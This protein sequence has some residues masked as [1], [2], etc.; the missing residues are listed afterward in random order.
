[1]DVRSERQM[2]GLE[3]SH[4]E[5]ADYQTNDDTERDFHGTKP[6]NANA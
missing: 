6:F 1:M 2:A 3:I 5:K 4:G